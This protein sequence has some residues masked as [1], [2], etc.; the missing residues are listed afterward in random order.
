MDSSHDVAI[1]KTCCLIFIGFT[2]AALVKMIATKL[3]SS[4]WSAYNHLR[5]SSTHSGPNTVSFSQTNLHVN[6][7]EKSLW[8]NKIYYK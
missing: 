1:Y 2:T 7:Y 4:N 3:L 5:N 6:E 8:I